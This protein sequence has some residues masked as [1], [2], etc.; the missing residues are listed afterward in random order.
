MNEVGAGSQTEVGERG[1][2]RKHLRGIGSK[3]WVR[4]RVI[5]KMEL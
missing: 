4:V 2:N 1:G 5:S 3:M